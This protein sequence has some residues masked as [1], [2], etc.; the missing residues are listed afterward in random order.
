MCLLAAACG[1]SEPASESGST[2]GAG[3][4]S[5]AEAEPGM[6][7]VNYVHMEDG[8]HYQGSFT[9]TGPNVRASWTVTNGGSEDAKPITMAPERFE[10]VWRGLG[11]IRDFGRFV[12]TDVDLE[13]QPDQYH[14]IT[15]IEISGERREMKT[16]A[17]PVREGSEPFQDWLDLIEVPW[18]Q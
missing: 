1:G 13:M 18:R 10:Q 5:Q 2:A 16:Y 15:T 9:K 8:G 6:R 4:E 12:V 11:T 3:A 7:T 14:V 17:I